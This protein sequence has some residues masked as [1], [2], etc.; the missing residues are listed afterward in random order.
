MKETDYGEKYAEVYDSLY[1]PPSTAMIDFLFEE[2]G[3][4]PVLELGIG[5]G[6]VA[7]EL[8]K[9]GVN[10]HGIEISPKMIEVLKRKK[11][12]KSIPVHLSSFS[13]IPA[14]TK[15]SMIFAVFNTFFGLLHVEDQV[16]CFESIS[17]SLLP[18]GKLVIEA[19][20]PDLSSFSR[21]QALSVISVDSNEVVLSAS[22]VNVPEQT[23]HSQKIYISEKGIKMFPTAYRFTWPSELDLMGKNANIP[24]S[25]RFSNWNRD[26][27]SRHSNV[28]VSIYMKGSV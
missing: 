17:K 8:K 21:N 13:Q 15:Y 6:R 25:Q 10:V 2:A 16:T 5:T 22:L 26:P 1:P 4:G 3:N 24:L 11:G 28:H 20:V 27:Y 14:S 12:G 7:L 9:R 23:L 19:I 18:G